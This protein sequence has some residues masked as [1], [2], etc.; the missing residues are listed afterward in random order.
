LALSRQFADINVIGKTMNLKLLLSK[1][2]IG[3]FVCFLVACGGS[4]GSST[5]DPVVT[6][7]DGDGV[8]NEADAFP[9]DPDE[10]ADAD[11]DT[12]GDNA[13]NCVATANQS[14]VDSDVNGSGDACD[15]MPVNY[16]FTNSM[17]T[18][19]SDSVSYTGQTA[20]HLLI[21]GMVDYMSSMV[22]SGKTKEDFI[23]DLNLYITGDGV[24]DTP[25]GFTLKNGDANGD[26]VDNAATY[27]AVSSNKNLNGKIAGG[28]GQ[29]GGETSRLIDGEFFGWSDGLSIGS[30]P[31]SLVEL[32]IDQL[33]D[34][35]A[36]GISIS[37]PTVTGDVNVASV[38][39]DS[40][41]RNQRQ[42][43]QK[44]LLGAVTFSQGT[45]DYFQADFATQ[46]SEQ[47]EGKNYTAGEHNYDEAFGYYGAARD[48]NSYTDLEARAK[49]GRDD[50]KNGYHDTDSNGLIDPRS[51]FNFGNSQN[52]AKRDVGSADNANPTDFSK[53]AMDAF[54]AGRQ[55]LSNAAN[56]GSMSPE[57]EAALAVHI[58][59]AALTWEKCI[60]ATVIHYINDVTTDMGNFVDGS[61]ADVDNFT[62][63]G[64]HWSEMKGFALGLQF[65]PFSPFRDEA[66][67]AVDLN[68][69][70]TILNDFGDAPML[71]DGSQGN[72]VASD[73]DTAIAAYINKLAAARLTLQDA[74]GFDADNVAGW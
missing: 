72:V 45:N 33:A 31:I 30:L 6:D 38:Q 64:K 50:F 23:T 68:D 29:G 55:I 27:G 28:N 71:A 44:F 47:E 51:E 35:A 36:D 67:T 4:G 13:D 43:L 73:T 7:S 26:D 74:Y 48:N 57:E 17:F 49:S 56:L 2:L 62:D 60:A 66:V 34:Q 46:I 9:N 12:V 65:S 16:E 61:F 25:T 32:W 5:P 1:S 40:Y 53:E 22:E 8:A 24:N 14:Q 52:C 37:V 54:I 11:S 18:A 3:L 19:D 59:S 39:Y 42:L 69:L 63:L 70:K 41:G 15:P 20:R 10:S 21:S 58:K